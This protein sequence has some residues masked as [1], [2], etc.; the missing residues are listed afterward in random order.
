MSSFALTMPT[1]SLVRRSPHTSVGSQDP[2]EPPQNTKTA[3]AQDPLPS[4][5]LADFGHPSE[6]KLQR[7]RQLQRILK[8]WQLT[9]NGAWTSSIF[10]VQNPFL[11]W[12]G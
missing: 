8:L 4:T 12:I 9:S 11:P 3:M 5:E 2:M 1:S 10:H 7:R 6:L